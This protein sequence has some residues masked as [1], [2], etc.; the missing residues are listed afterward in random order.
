M[1]KRILI[2]LSIC[3]SVLIFLGIK[4]TE[5][6]AAVTPAPVN[7]SVSPEPADNQIDKTI[8]YYDLKVTPGQKETLKFK[9]NNNDT[10]NHTYSIMINRATTDINGVIDYT[11][12]NSVPEDK[13]NY[14]VE[15]LVDYPKEVAVPAKSS[16]EVSVNLKAPAGDFSGELLGGILVDED[17]QVTKNVTKGVTLKSKYNYVIGLQLQQNTD[18]IKPDLKLNRVYETNKSGQIYVDD[19]L[20]NDVPKLEKNVSVNAK[21]VPVNSKKAVLESSKQNM[22]IAPDSYFDYPVNVNTTTGV[23]K[24]K[25]LKPGTYTMYLN[26]KA[27]G[28]QNLWNLKRKFTISSGQNKKLN[29]AVPNNSKSKW[30]IISA[31]VVMMMIASGIIWFYR[32]NKK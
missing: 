1:K 3:I 27:N 12:H 26:V 31:V 6:Q 14:N 29:K 15:N 9:I 21:V 5:I 24:N 13:L 8:S 4:T 7:Y 17:N 10:N 25:R 22:S 16:K 19:K 2:L 18:N 11:E 20:D 32:K 23:N 28:G 30:I